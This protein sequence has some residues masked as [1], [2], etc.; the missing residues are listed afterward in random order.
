MKNT[1]T[2]LVIAG[3][4]FIALATIFTSVAKNVSHYPHAKAAYSQS[5]QEIFYSNYNEVIN[6]LFLTG[7]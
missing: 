4:T 1:I 2:R 5:G 3:I 7:R 6:N